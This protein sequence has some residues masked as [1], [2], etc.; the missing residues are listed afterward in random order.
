MPKPIEYKPPQA[1]AESRGLNLSHELRKLRR[2]LRDRAR[3]VPAPI[4]PGRSSQRRAATV[5][6]ILAPS[7]A[8]PL[9]YTSQL[10]EADALLVEEADNPLR[11]Y[12]QLYER[13]NGLRSTL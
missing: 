13:R 11:K 5:R 9:E 7:H 3:R 6:D 2:R 1:L 10:A 12:I 4:F 8:E